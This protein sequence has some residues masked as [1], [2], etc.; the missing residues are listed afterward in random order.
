MLNRTVHV[1]MN[2]C[3]IR[4]TATA[5]CPPGGVL[6]PLLWCLLVDDLLSDLREAGFYAQ[7]Y[8]DDITIIVGGRFVGVVSERMQVGRNVVPKGRV[9]C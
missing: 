1:P 6:S 2:L 9:K 3:N 8:A 4:A 5:A 7:G